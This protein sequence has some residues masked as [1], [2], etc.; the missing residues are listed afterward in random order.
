MLTPFILIV[1][2]FL[3]LPAILMIWDSFRSDG[4]FSIINYSTAITNKYYLKAISN[5][6]KISIIS[7]IIGLSISSLCAYSLSNLKEKSQNHIITIL[8]MTSNF[9][10]VP[11]SLGYIL[12]LGNTGMFVLFSKHFGFDIFNDFNLYSWIG[13]IVVYIYFQI[14]IG[15][16]FLYPAFIG[17]RKEWREAAMILGANSFYFWIKIGVPILLPSIVGTLSMLFANAMGAYSTAYALVGNNY[18]LLSIRIGSLI[19]GD[20]VPKP[21]L[22]SAL[23]IILAM[24]SISMMFINEKMSKYL[25]KGLK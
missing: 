4:S 13:L 25:K 14:P 9:S 1:V 20:I 16:M 23:A 18:N 12:L 15:I 17:I 19:V 24:T 6:I 22:A 5:S 8:N 2:L 10:G 11:L 21:E 3:L 7:S